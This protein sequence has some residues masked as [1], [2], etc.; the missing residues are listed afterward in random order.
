MKKLVDVYMAT[1]WRQGHAVISIN[2]LRQQPEFGTATIIC[3]NWTDG[4]WEYI[5]NELSGDSRILLFRGDN[6]KGSNEKLRFINNGSNQ[7]IMLADDDLI[8]PS[9]Y[10]NKLIG[11]CDKYNSHVSLHGVILKRGIINSYYRDRVVFRALGSV[12]RDYVVD[13]ASN[14]GSLFKRSFYNDLDK[15]YDF[16]GNESMDDIYV[17]Y[18]AKKSGI[19]R[20]V[21]AHSEGYLKHKEQFSEDNYVFN[22]YALTGNDKVQTEFINNVFNYL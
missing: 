8:Y 7:Y 6:A 12:D 22:K 18:F 1:L 5:N 17:N 13:I 10:L 16:C 9:D 20:V 14:C 4:Q 15:W 2:S 21:L 11:G 19:M 3:N